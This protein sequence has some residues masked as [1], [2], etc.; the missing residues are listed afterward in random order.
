[1]VVRESPEDI[2]QQS[3][4]KLDLNTFLK[5]PPQLQAP[6]KWRRDRRIYRLATE[7][8][9]SGKSL[10]AVATKYDIPRSTL[11]D[12]LKKSGLIPAW[13]K[14][15]QAATIMKNRGNS[16]NIVNSS[17]A[18]TTIPRQTENN[19]SLDPPVHVLMS[20]YS[21][22]TDDSHDES[23]M[24]SAETIDQKLIKRIKSNPEV[25]IRTH[26]KEQS[27]IQ[28]DSC[29]RI[30]PEKES[31]QTEI[32]LKIESDDTKSNDQFDSIKSSSHEESSPSTLANEHYTTN[33]NPS[34]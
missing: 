20:N 14:S 32:Q 21:L 23:N 6:N 34:S 9:L 18:S 22:W 28:L 13:R 17:T 2:D 5:G 11:H 12:Y 19:V 25:E 4:S 3:D 16:K 7:D 26:K 30:S 31:S 24:I 27:R 10:I 29:I 15:R 33:T 8:L 1:M